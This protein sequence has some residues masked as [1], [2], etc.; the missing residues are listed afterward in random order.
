[1]KKEM[2]DFLTAAQARGCPVQ[3]GSDMLFEMIPPYL[4]FFGFGTTTSEI[5]RSV[6]RLNY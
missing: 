3:V 6:A 5:L 1:M 2:T 4:D